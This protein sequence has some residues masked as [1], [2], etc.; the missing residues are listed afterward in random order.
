MSQAITGV[1]PELINIVREN[2]QTLQPCGLEYCC[3]IIISN[4]R[5]EVIT[6]ETWTQTATLSA[7]CRAFHQTR[8]RHPQARPI[9]HTPDHWFITSTFEVS[10][11]GVTKKLIQSSAKSLIKSSRCTSLGLEWDSGKEWALTP[12]GHVITFFRK[13]KKKTKTHTNSHN[14]WLRSKKSL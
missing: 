9:S 1:G 6:K 3:V 11:G 12:P 13:N 2:R 7:L 5:R 14:I 10:R 8:S 4:L